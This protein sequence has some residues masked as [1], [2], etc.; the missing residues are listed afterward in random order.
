MIIVLRLAAWNGDAL[1]REKG[2][3]GSA[4]AGF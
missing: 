3:E 1:P 4:R 2:S